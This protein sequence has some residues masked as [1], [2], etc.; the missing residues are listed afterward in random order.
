MGRKKI[1]VKYIENNVTRQ[2]TFSKRR[3]GI[4]KKADALTRLYNVEVAVLI[5]SPARR[6]YIYGSP[7]FESVVKRLRNPNARKRSSSSLKQSRFLKS[8]AKLDRL[9]EELEL[10]KEREKVS[11]PFLIFFIVKMRFS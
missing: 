3:A 10:Q 6:P 5:N 11:V 4:F 7:C 2:I 8:Q 9:M 1:E